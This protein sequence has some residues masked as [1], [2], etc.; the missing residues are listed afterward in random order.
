MLQAD[1]DGPETVVPLARVCE[2][3]RG[4]L[5]ISGT[6]RDWRM[7]D[8]VLVR[9]AD[10]TIGGEIVTL[11][12]REGAG[13]ILTDRQPEGVRTGRSGRTFCEWPAISPHDGWI[14]RI[15]DP[16]GQP[17][18]GVPLMRGQ[19]PYALRAA[20]PPASSRRRLGGRLETGMRIFNTL[21][22][23]VCGQRIGLFAGSGVGKSTLLG[24][25][26]RHVEADVMVIALIGERGGNCASS[27]KMC[28][29]PKGWRAA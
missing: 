2:V 3:G 4:L 9:G 10:A 18:D 19:R 1:R 26:A 11:D 24:T 17:L 20:P 8:R 6:G 16:F 28:L 27:P 12:R 7:G 14:G 29:A 25:F 15:V 21:L 13:V 5:R 22:P 23:L